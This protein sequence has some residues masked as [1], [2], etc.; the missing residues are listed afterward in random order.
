MK[1]TNQRTLRAEDARSASAGSG[2]RPEQHLWRTT[3]SRPHPSPKAACGRGRRGRFASSFLARFS[4]GLQPRVQGRSPGHEGVI[5]NP[6]GQEGSGWRSPM[7]SWPAR[8][9]K[10]MQIG[11]SIQLRNGGFSRTNPTPA[12]QGQ[13]VCFHPFC[14]RNAFPICIRLFASRRARGF[15]GARLVKSNIVYNLCKDMVYNI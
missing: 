4:L 6:R 13:E 8:R 15:G 5:G 2:Q 1:P 12:T 9:A 3:T 7:S 10:H 14:K 11:N